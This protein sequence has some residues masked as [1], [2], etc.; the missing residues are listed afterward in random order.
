MSSEGL[1]EVN[2]SAASSAAEV[3]IDWSPDGSQL[4]FAADG[5][6]WVMQ[7]DGSGRT[8]LTQNT[9]DEWQGSWSPDGSTIVYARGNDLW[10]MDAEGT[11]ER[12]LLAR[13]EI[14]S[15]PEWSPDGQKIA[16]VSR[17][18]GVT[19]VWIMD[20]DG[21]SPHSLTNTIL[22]ENREPA[23]AP[24]GSRIAF[25]SD[26]DGDWDIWMM[27]PDGTNPAHLT[28]SPADERFVAW[29]S[30]NRNPIARPD[31]GH[32][33]VGEVVTI[34]VI[35]NDS[36]PDGEPVI[37]VDVTRDPIDGIVGGGTFG[38][39]TYIHGGILRAGQPNPYSD[40]FEYEIEDPRHGTARS[41][42]TV[43]IYAGFSDVPASNV[44]SDDI[45]WLAEQGITLGCNPPDNTL[46]CPHDPVTRG[47]MAAFLVRT[48]H[49]TDSGVGNLFLDDD[50]SVIEADIDKLGVAG[51]TRGCNPP[52]ND[53]F[54]PSQLVTRGQMAAFLA[55]AV[56]LTDLGQSNLFGDDDGTVFEPDIDKLG[57]TGVSKGC[58]P[59][60]NDRFCPDE[61]VTR[62]QMAAFI[63]RAVDYIT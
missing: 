48:L 60:L 36:D 7:A 12:S 10:L 18:S 59:P 50:D 35:S 63:K 56:K 15:D 6:I 4:L 49:Y 13:T 46:F 33:R 5:D 2:L 58:N 3:V 8:R 11:N 51:V 1:N 22:Y 34:D 61:Y 41:T 23:W 28:D 9:L 26:R 31:V 21:S 25:S 19:N 16:F 30:E 39:V 62:E 29:E 37:L 40:T 53:R 54:C 57:A 47:Q 44:F 24:D 20:A 17:Q 43:W 42:V 45:N 52:L 38:A 14:D 55:R 27:S 32:V